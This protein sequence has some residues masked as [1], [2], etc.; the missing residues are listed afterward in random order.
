MVRQR[1][2]ARGAIL[3]HEGDRGCRLTGRWS[4]NT[5]GST[6]SDGLE[7]SLAGKTLRRAVIWAGRMPPSAYVRLDTSDWLEVSLAGKKLRRA[8]IW[9]GS[10]AA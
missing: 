1:A 2:P 9:A 3:E 6:Q 7:V 8:V 5:A 4:R 10:H